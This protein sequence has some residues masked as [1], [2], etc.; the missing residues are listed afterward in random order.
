MVSKKRRYGLV[1]LFIL[2][3]A[4]VF[5]G[6]S[7]TEEADSSTNDTTKN[8]SSSNSSSKNGSENSNDN[9]K[10]DGKTYTIKFAHVSNEEHHYNQGALKF[11]ELIEE[12]SDGRIKVEVYPNSEFGG[13]RE[14]LE[15]LQLGTVQMGFSTSGVM[16]GF[17]PDWAIYDLA[18]F[19]ESGQ[20]ALEV[21]LGPFGQKIDEKM[22]DVGFRNLAPLNLGFR[23]VYAHK[24]IN[25]LD[26]MKGLKIRVIESPSYISGM[27]A[28]GASPVPIS[29]PE[30]YS[31][32]QQKVVDAAENS[33]DLY[34]ITKHYE[35]AKHYSLTKHFFVPVVMVISEKYYQS[36][37]EDLQKLVLEASRQAGEW[38]NELIKK[39]G[40]EA[41][42]NLAKEGVT[43]TEIN[44]LKPFQDAAKKSWSEVAEDIPN[45]EQ[46]LE[47][48]LKVTG[49]SLD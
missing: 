31:S 7:G 15:G 42:A 44:D 12:S 43:V 41:Y 24:P 39:Q 13:E 29:W 8:S 46:L 4:L 6:C 11:K 40:E 45:G 47:E 2:M 5:A 37:P 34:Y 21:Q 28:L 22:L 25:S 27:K 14:I 1:I 16:S 20:E 17:V 49:K 36:L 33:V 18:Y 38:E 19:F 10:D 23:N 9:K 30:L 48:L 3:A 26:D 32:L 35:V